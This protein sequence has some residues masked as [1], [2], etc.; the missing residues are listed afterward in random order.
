MHL[1]YYTQRSIKVPIHLLFDSP[2]WGE[3]NDPCNRQSIT[4]RLEDPDF[5]T[6]EFC[7]NAPSK[8]SRLDHPIEH[9]I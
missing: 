4:K 8:T 2:Q 9:M 6:S 3:L 5:G 7:T 1:L